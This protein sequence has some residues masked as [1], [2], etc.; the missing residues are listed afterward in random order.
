IPGDGYLGAT[1]PAAFGTWAFALK[2]FGTLTLR[3]VL[4]PAIRYAEEGFPVYPLLRDGLEKL[5]KRF[6]AEWPTSAALY[7][8]GGKVPAIGDNHVNREWAAIMKKA[9]EV[10]AK[11]KKHGRA[12]AIQAAID[13][14]YKG[15]VAEKI[16]EWMKKPIKDASK[17]SHAGMLTKE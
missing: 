11:H 8:P 6:K 13:W 3:D 7:L 1:V 2:R 17:R 5:A 9:C 12:E 4:A 15:E 14:W 10:E 16:V